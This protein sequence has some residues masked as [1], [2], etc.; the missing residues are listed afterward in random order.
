MYRRE[1]G[2][3]GHRS[4]LIALG[5]AVFIYPVSREEEE[6]FI[7]LFLDHGVNH[8]DVAP[9]YGDAEVRLGPWVK[10]YRENLFLAC[11]TGKRTKNEA[12][13]E[14]TRSLQRL[15]TEY[16]DLYQ[17]HGLDDPEEL[18][19]ALGENG[20]MRAILDAKDQN[21]VRHIGITSHNPENIMR[22]LE[23][24]DFDTILLPVNYVLLAHPQPQND[25]RPVLSLAKKRGCGVIAM[26]SIAKGPWLTE[27]RTHNTWYEPFATQPEIDRALWFTLSQNVTTAASSSD[28]RIA[29][30][31]LD[32][33][34]RFSTM[35]KEEEQDLLVKA[36]E[37]SPL[38]PRKQ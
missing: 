24:F 27:K 34:E 7:R 2:R 18:K 9:T 35:S 12:W 6:E 38:F 19:T 23:S 33:A 8:I 37:Y 3:T 14:L 10:E 13:Q 28:I 21:L 36:A 31:Q 1:L 17:L 22:A 32:A 25:F 5:G 15:Q 4:T 16:F 26:K 30:M 29:K 20:A 11:K